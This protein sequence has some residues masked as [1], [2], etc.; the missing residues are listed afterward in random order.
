MKTEVKTFHGKEMYLFYE[1]FGRWEKSVKRYCEANGLDFNIIDAMPKHYGIDFVEV[2]DENGE[3]VLTVYN[4]FD[5]EGVVRG[6]PKR[7]LTSANV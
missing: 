2:I 3:V 5:G 1:S 6:N 7:E 4:G